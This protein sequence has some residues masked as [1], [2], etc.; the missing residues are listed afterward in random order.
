MR[1]DEVD[2]STEELKQ[3]LRGV[4]LFA[5]DCTREKSPGVKSMGLEV[6]KTLA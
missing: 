1:Q 6:K 3:R 4:K 2:A 5:Q